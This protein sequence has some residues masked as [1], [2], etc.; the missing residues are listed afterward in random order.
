MSRKPILGLLPFFLACLISAPLLP[1][2][3]S[4]VAVIVNSKN[5][6][7][8]ISFAE[9]KKIFAG[10]KHT[11]PGGTPIKLLVRAPECHERTV[12]LRI[13]GMSE[14]AYKQYWTGQVVR[15]EADGEPMAVPSLGM[16]KEA[17]SA[18]PGGIGM[19][20]AENVKPGMKVIKIDGRMP[21]DPR[22]PIR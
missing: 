7:E 2:Q 15:G 14:A 10:E 8:N 21:G 9:L 3:T 17:V 4:D 13:L 5:S 20:D 18:L 1:A 11:W 12:L 6:V 16:M 19:V 22:Y